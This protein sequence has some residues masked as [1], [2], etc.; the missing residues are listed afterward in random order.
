VP[1]LILDSGMLQSEAQGDFFT[2]DDETEPEQAPAATPAEAQ[3]R[4]RETEREEKREEEAPEYS[5]RVF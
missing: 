3:A 4:Q 5:R 2:N 1:N